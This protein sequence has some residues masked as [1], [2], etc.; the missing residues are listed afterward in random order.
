[1]SSSRAAALKRKDMKIAEKYKSA[2]PQNRINDLEPLVRQLKGNEKEIQKVIAEWWEDPTTTAVEPEWEDV[3]RRKPTH[4]GR[5]HSNSN[6]G[7]G[8]GNSS[9]YNKRN[10]GTGRGNNRYNNA[11]RGRGSNRNGN[12]DRPARAAHRADS[13]AAAPSAP[14]ATAAAAAVVDAP[15]RDPIVKPTPLVPPPVSGGGASGSSSSVGGGNVW[16]TKGSAHLITLQAAEEQKAAAAAAYKAQHHHHSQRVEASVELEPD[17]S[18]TWNDPLGIDSIPASAADAAAVVENVV[19]EAEVEEVPVVEEEPEPVSKSASATAVHDA[20]PAVPPPPTTST[21][22]T[23]A[24]PATTSSVLN[25]GRWGSSEHENAAG[26]DQSAFEFVFGSSGADDDLSP[27]TKTETDPTAVA[28]PASDAAATAASPSRPPPGLSLGGMPPMPP[29]VVHV[30]ELEDKL[31]NVTLNEKENETTAKVTEAAAPTYATQPPPPTKAT[32]AQTTAHHTP[33]PTASTTTPNYP[34]AYSS[35]DVNSTTADQQQQQAHLAAAAAGPYGVNMYAYPGHAMPP[36]MHPMAAA[37]AY[38]PQSAY[39]YGAGA[40]M[41]YGTAY[42]P[43]MNND[44]H[45]T[46]YGNAQGQHNSG[47]RSNRRP[48]YNNRNNRNNAEQQQQAQMPY[49]MMYHPHPAAFYGGFDHMNAMAAGAPPYG[50][51]N[52]QQQTQGQQPVEANGSTTGTD[53]SAFGK[54][55]SSTAAAGGGWG[56]ANGA[57]WQQQA[58]GG[59]GAAAQQHPAAQQPNSGGWQH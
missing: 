14:P 39:G 5:Y 20:E 16:A 13:T 42:N 34:S 7:N 15:V 3:S 50:Y 37:A 30:H 36:H 19:S 6:S 21:I 58:A 18:T 29:G 11:G 54:N 12:R 4:T 32:T 35:Y 33:N 2:C 27:T 10:G 47:H 59:W 25:L 56:A 38:G 57:G 28:E 9:S 40:F 52:M 48:H 17:T 26:A 45:H 51:A 1:M 23:A 49:G 46:P 22:P 41:G 53:G 55:E 31:E 44:E 8:N 24:E 43:N